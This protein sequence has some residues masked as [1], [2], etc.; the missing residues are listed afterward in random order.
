[1]HI[2]AESLVEGKPCLIFFTNPCMV[3]NVSKEQPLRNLK[4]SVCGRMAAIINREACL[5]SHYE[6]FRT[7]ASTAENSPQNS[8]QETIFRLV[9]KVQYKSESIA[10]QRN[11][12]VST[13]TGDHGEM[14]E[15]CGEHLSRIANAWNIYKD[16][17]SYLD[18]RIA[19]HGAI[20]SWVY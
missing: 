2:R 16:R 13:V 6:I 8:T 3:Q 5:I 14:V 19:I 1:M 10:L 20:P 7:I 12:S 18:H 4:W 17:R 9:C 15:S 11:H